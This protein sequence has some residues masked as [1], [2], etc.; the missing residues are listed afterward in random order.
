MVELLDNI[1]LADELPKRSYPDYLKFLGLLLLGWLIIGL[2]L[3]LPY[4]N[5][6]FFSPRFP[7][8]FDTP[9]GALAVHY[10]LMYF[11]YDS[12]LMN[13]QKR[14]LCYYFLWVSVPAFVFGLWH[15]MSKSGTF[16]GPKTFEDLFMA[17][18]LSTVGGGVS[19]AWG[20]LVYEIRQRQ[21]QLPLNPYLVF[22]SLLFLESLVPTPAYELSLAIFVLF[23][24]YTI[25]RLK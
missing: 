15:F 8:L 6:V 5:E 18:V 7:L 24:A 25:Y 2:F 20:V 22:L 10:L 21:L 12:I 17:T 11:F 3:L 14:V 13:R 9:I 19:L 1:R 23:I 16:W 4:Y